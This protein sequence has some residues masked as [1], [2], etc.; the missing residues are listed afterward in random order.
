MFD[1]SSQIHT[2][3]RSHYL[4]NIDLYVM[5]HSKNTK[6]A[7]RQMGIL[8]YKKLQKNKDA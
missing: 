4:F 7:R 2:D 5:K 6:K 8:M 1:K 3:V